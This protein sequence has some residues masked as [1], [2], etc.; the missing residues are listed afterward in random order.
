LNE[1]KKKENRNLKNFMPFLFLRISE[2]RQ[3][4]K[5]GFSGEE[6]KKPPFPLG[7]GGDFK[8]LQL[9]QLQELW[10]RELYKLF[11]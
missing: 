10:Q 6:E 1:S 7:K 4:T 3:K 11:L 9:T 5:K 8:N 2:K